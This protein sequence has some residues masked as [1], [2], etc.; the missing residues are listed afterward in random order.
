MASGKEKIFP[1]LRQRM[2]MKKLCTV[3]V[4]VI[5][6]GARRMRQTGSGWSQGPISNTKKKKLVLSWFN[7]T[8]VF[9]KIATQ[10]KM[11]MECTPTSVAYLRLLKKEARCPCKSA[12]GRASIEL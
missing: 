7:C 3:D 11:V 2:H 5:D 8:S 1:A 4:G 12:S 6:A 10:D 9:A